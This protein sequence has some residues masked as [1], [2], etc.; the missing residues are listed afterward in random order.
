MI[1]IKINGFDDW[2]KIKIGLIKV[3]YAFDLF[4]AFT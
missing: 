1:A 3:Y 2:I 4:L